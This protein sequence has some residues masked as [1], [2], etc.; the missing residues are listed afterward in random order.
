MA[1]KTLVRSAAIA[2]AMA[3]APEALAQAQAK[4]ELTVTAEGIASDG[5]IDT[6]YAFCVPAAEGHVKEGPDKSIG[7]AWSKGPEGT[8]SYAII[9]VDP[10]VPASF[11]DAGK[12]GRTL[13]EGM[14][15]RSFYHWVLYDI[16]AEK[17]QIP[18]YTDSQTIVKHGKT[19][20]KTPYGTRGV[21]DYAPYFA[22]DPERAGVYAGYDGPCPPWN[23]ERIHHYHIKVFA[24]D[25]ES[26]GLSGPVT[27][28]RVMD[29]IA[30]HILA[31]GEVVGK[32]T[33][34]PDA[35]K[36]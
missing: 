17:S 3:H 6:D 35:K 19:E 7:L 22:S 34:N 2:L 9:M 30:T 18:A 11:D 5:Y 16:P 23:D 21:N 4:P 33:L 12:E 31:Q 25:V 26:L 24:L 32:Y 14:D 1:M 13:P 15:R 36:P 8:R 27:G 29:A 28:P 10:D 20:L